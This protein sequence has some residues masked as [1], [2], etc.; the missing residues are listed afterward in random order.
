MS[1]PPDLTFFLCNCGSKQYPEAL[2]D[3][4]GIFIANVC[5]YCRS[6][7]MNLYRPEIFI[8]PDYESD[9]DIDPS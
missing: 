8:N 7:V 3:A 1:E 5:K 2:R 9:E 6:K 4:R